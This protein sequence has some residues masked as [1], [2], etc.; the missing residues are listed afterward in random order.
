MSRFEWSQSPKSRIASL[1][2]WI[3]YSANLHS[4]WRVTATM[5]AIVNGDDKAEIAGFGNVGGYVS[6]RSK[7][8][9]SGLL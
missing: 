5:L 8:T 3:I 1:Q 4:G 7:V 2:C 9:A 6:L